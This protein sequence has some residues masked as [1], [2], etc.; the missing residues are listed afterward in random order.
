MG[1]SLISKV[2]I[3]HSVRKQV[4][5]KD[6]S[7]GEHFDV[8]IQ[9]FAVTHSNLKNHLKLQKSPAPP[10]NLS[11]TVDNLTLAR[12]CFKQ[13]TG[14]FSIRKNLIYNHVTFK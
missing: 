14:D 8:L 9:K 10:T 6:Q 12:S 5:S 1:T 2:I 3:L 4:M 13:A 11:I 7:S